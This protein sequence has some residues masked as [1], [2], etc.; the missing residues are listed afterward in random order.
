[1]KSLWPVFYYKDK[2]EL[3]LNLTGL[4]GLLRKV[5][6]DTGLEPVTPPCKGRCS[7][8]WANR[9]MHLKGYSVYLNTKN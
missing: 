2:T 8:N 7:P 3:I 6:G 4:K 9:P 5:V 1:M